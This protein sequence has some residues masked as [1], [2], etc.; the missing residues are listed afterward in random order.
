M[1]TNQPGH[2]DEPR[3]ALLKEWKSTP[4]LPPGVQEQVWRRLE[5]A[6]AQPIIS[7]PLWTVWTNW[8]ATVLMGPA[9]ATVEQQA[10]E[11]HRQE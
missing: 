7:V 3:R 11:G 6:E 9:L 5:R 1:N 2:E 10:H 8:I 4:S